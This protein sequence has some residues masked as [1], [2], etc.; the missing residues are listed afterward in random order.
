[1]AKSKKIKNINGIK[2]IKGDIV[3]HNGKK[4]TV[5]EREYDNYDGRSYYNLALG[6]GATR[7]ST[8][9]TTWA[10]SDKFSV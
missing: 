7:K 1:M 6:I 2:A 3:L 10:R 4:W 5:L 8:N 9:A